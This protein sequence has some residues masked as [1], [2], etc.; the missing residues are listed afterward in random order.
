LQ[1]F[2]NSSQVQVTSDL[3]EHRNKGGL[4][5]PSY[6][7]YVVVKTADSILTHMMKTC[8]TTQP[9]ILQKTCLKTLHELTN[10]GGQ[11]IFSSLDD[12]VDDEINSHKILMIEKIVML[13]TSMRLKHHCRTQNSKPDKI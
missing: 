10:N 6:Q 13:F 1:Y 9:H 11:D 8:I 4:V 5:T 2:H 3:I 7:V 12:N